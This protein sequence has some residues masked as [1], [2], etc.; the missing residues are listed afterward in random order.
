MD[1]E[2][3]STAT[4]MDALGGTQAVADLTG[5]TYAAAF[6]WR[7][8]KAFPSNTYLVMTAALAEKGAGAPDS[9]WG[10]VEAPKSEDASASAA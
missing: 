5:R 7:S 8:F 10:M 4:V 3:T 9:L 1:H 6:N 2:L